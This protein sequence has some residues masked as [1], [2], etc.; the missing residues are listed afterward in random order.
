MCL[1]CNHIFFKGHRTHAEDLKNVRVTVFKLCK[2]HRGCDQTDGV[3]WMILAESIEKFRA[4]RHC[5]YL[6]KDKN[7]I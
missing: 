4:V 5:L 6:V 3:I 2:F 1:A 7:T